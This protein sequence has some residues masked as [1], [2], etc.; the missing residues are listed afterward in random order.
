MAGPMP[1]FV[2]GNRSSTA[3]AITCAAEWRIASSSLCAPASS[4]SSADPRSGA[5]N[6]S[7]TSSASATAASCSAIRLASMNHET[8][9]PRQDER[10]TGA[11][12]VPPAFAAHMCVP[13]SRAA[14]TG[15]PGP[16]HRPLTGGTS[17]VVVAGL[18]AVARF[19]G[20]ADRAK[21]V[22]IDAFRSAIVPHA[23]GQPRWSSR[24]STT[25]RVGFPAASY[26]TYTG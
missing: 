9:R 1:S 2:P 18:P 16:V 6:S 24:K 23:P 3:S 21:R 8:S 13:R 20:P 22:P 12:A 14:L 26:P 5:T 7:S 25:T 10:L 17:L 11:P 15:G 4:S 19:S